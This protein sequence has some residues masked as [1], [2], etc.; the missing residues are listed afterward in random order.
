MRVALEQLRTAGSLMFSTWELLLVAE[1]ELEIGEHLRAQATIE[2]AFE[3]INRTRDYWCE[4]ELYRVAAEILLGTPGRSVSEAEAYLRRAIE[5]AGRQQAKWWEL[6]A[7]KSLARLLCETN[8]HDEARAML[9]AV[10]QW[11]TEGF[12]TAD[13]KDAKALLDELS[14]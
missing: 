14:A 2:E 1:V 10:Y 8:R 11:F 6:R 9:A 4:A 13:L 5:I 3:N 7:T 12:D